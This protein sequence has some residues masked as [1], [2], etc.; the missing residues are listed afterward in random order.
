MSTPIMREVVEKV[1]DEVLRAQKEKIETRLRKKYKHH[2]KVYLGRANRVLN[3]FGGDKVAQ[4]YAECGCGGDLAV[5]EMFIKLGR[6]FAEECGQISKRTAN[7]L[8]K[9]TA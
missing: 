3:V 1:L 2:Y 5:V 8:K 9:N 7:I 4:R 6:H